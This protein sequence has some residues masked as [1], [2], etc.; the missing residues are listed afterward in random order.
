MRLVIGNTALGFGKNHNFFQFGLLAE[1]DFLLG[2]SQEP[3]DWVFGLWH[4]RGR[5]RRW[6]LRCRS[7]SR[8]YRSRCWF[9]WRDWLWYWFSWS[10]RSGNGWCFNR[11][12]NRSRGRVCYRWCC[13]NICFCCHKNFNKEFFERPPRAKKTPWYSTLLKELKIKFSFLI[14]LSQKQKEL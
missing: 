2:F 13:V 14:F 10:R 3:F 9:D 12:F 8:G 11:R 4:W 5:G 6:R 1:L 7:W